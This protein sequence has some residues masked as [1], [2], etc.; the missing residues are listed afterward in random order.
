MKIKS[1]KH[2]KEKITVYDIETE[3]HNYILSNGVISHNTM[4]MYNPLAIG[5]GKGVYFASSSIVLGSTKAK[6]KDSD[7][8]ISGMLIN[9]KVE[10][11]RYS[12]EHSKLKFLIEYSGGIHPTYGILEDLV[13]MGAV[14]K[15]SQ[16][17]YSRNF[18]FLDG[19]KLEDKKWR[20]K[21][22]WRDWKDFFVPILK[23]RKVHEYFENKYTFEE[24][25]IIDEDFDFTPQ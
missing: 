25:D 23:S 14:I 6:Q 13:E 12:K 9:S 18:E 22:I 21:E 15:P 17:W 2:K 19:D 4:D 20:E 16:G 8:E 3:C 7:G 11:G 10:K 24:S 5:G 1:I